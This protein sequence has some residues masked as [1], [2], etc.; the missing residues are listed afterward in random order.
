[1]FVKDESRGD[2]KNE[3]VIEANESVSFSSVISQSMAVRQ[4]A[5]RGGIKKEKSKQETMLDN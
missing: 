2:K 1:M 3:S 4:R 5:P